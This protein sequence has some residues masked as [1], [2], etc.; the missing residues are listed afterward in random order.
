M[1]SA[2]VYILGKIFTEDVVCTEYFALHPSSML[3]GALPRNC[4]T[5]RLWH[6]PKPLTPPVSRLVCGRVAS[7]LLLLQV[8]SSPFY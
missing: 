8:H 3:M 6:W 5:G 7:H 1:S 2:E 4:D